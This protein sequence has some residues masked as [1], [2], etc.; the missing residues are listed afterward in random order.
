MTKKTYLLA[1]AEAQA[2]LELIACPVRPDGTYNR[3]REACEALARDTLKKIEALLTPPAV[4]GDTATPLADLTQTEVLGSG[5]FTVYTDG[6]CKG[7]PGPAGWGVVIVENGEIRIAE[8]GYMGHATNQAAELAA[9]M[10]GLSRLPAGSVAELVSDSQY[11]LK[12]LTE[13]RKGWERRGW[14][15]ASGEPVANQA[16]WKRLY[17]AAD[18]LKVTTRWVRGHNGD[19]MNELCDELAGRAIANGMRNQTTV[20]EA[21]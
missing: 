18:K 16:H 13:W 6:G 11:T 1:L 14:L 10:E 2:T 15:N 7:N 5:P 19:R 21:A 3:G 9:A 12:G 20:A 4:E 17:A 8:G